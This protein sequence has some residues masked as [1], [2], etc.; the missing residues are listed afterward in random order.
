VPRRPSARADT[1]AV[2][3]AIVGALALGA[4][5]GVN[6]LNVGAVPDPL[7]EAYGVSLAT[8]GLFTT[9]LLVAHTAVQI[10]GGRAIDRFGARRVGLLLLGVAAVG[11]AL[12]TIAPEPAL[13]LGLRPLIGLSTGIGFVG[14][15]AYIRAAGGSPVAQ[16]IFGGAAMGGGG[17]ALAVVP[18][19]EPALDWRA[20]FVFGIAFSAAAALVLLLGPRD[21]R[22]AEGTARARATTLEIAVDRRLARIVVL[23][24]ATFGSGL[25]IGSWV[26]ALLVRLG[27]SQ[28]VAGAIGALTLALT[29]VSRPFGGWLLHRYPHRIARAL[30]GSLV[31]G[32]LGCA[33]LAAGGPVG[34]AVVAASAVGLGAGIAFAP[35]VTG[36]M[37]LRPDAPGAAVGAVN[38]WGNLVVLAATPLVGLAFSV[39]GGRIA[40]LAIAALWAA[41]LLALPGLRGLGAERPTE[42]TSRPADSGIRSRS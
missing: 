22:A 18:Q 8:V 16:G 20:P 25:L 24:T 19:F 35:V 23:H 41:A 27:H 1:W 37:R 15:I 34:A 14:G 30:A 31:L 7:A 11:N 36:T 13:A 12:T 10:P 40:F 5:S 3:R 9:V 21:A 38:M 28:G 6:I 33:G 17:L 39:G 2:R 4:A 42:A 32:A 29:M 26:V